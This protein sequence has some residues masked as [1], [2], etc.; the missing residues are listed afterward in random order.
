MEEDNARDDK[1]APSRNIVEGHD[2]TEDG[3]LLV[4]I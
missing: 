3:V 1:A 4:G 2:K